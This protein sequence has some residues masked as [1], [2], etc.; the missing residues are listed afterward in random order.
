MIVAINTRQ[1]FGKM[2]TAGIILMSEYDDDGGLVYAHSKEEALTWAKS[3]PQW[4]NVEPHNLHDGRLLLTT[5]WRE[6]D[7]PI[8]FLL[9]G[10]QDITHTCT[11]MVI[12]PV[13]TIYESTGYKVKA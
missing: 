2:E 3:F 12:Y 1:R 6:Y 10:H 7:D 9:E 4:A 5:E 11:Q 8:S 13:N